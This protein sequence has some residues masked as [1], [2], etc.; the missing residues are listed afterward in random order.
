MELI[1]K[2]PKGTVDIIPGESEKWSLVEAV[3]TDEA[4]LNGFSEIRTPVF[5]HTEL[6]L[7]SVGD[8]TDVVEKQMYTFE[9][10]GGRSITLRPEG[11]AGAV[12][13]M[14]ENGLYNGGYPVIVSALPMTLRSPSTPSAAPPAAQSTERR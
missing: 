12:R 6:F 7:R 1:T 4:E 9:D 2:A 10:K 3:M 5:E 13:A 14:L 8:T 11:T